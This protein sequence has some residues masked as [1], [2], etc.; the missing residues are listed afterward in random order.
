MVAHHSTNGNKCKMSAPVPVADGPPEVAPVVRQPKELLPPNAHWRADPAPPPLTTEASG[1]VAM[2]LRQLT[3]DQTDVTIWRGW[4]RMEPT[5]LSRAN[6][7]STSSALSHPH[8]QHGHHCPFLC[9][10]PESTR[11]SAKA[12]F[13]PAGFFSHRGAHP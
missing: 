2:A 7:E 6:P 9:Q 12:K 5:R 10:V 3:P 1:R 4:K 13:A 8:Q 11:H